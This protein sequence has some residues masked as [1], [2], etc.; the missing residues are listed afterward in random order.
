M[1]K[2]LH[3]NGRDL[4]S[5]ET[6]SGIK[7]GCPCSGSNFAIAADPLVHPHLGSIVFRSSHVGLLA[8]DVAIVARFSEW[9]LSQFIGIWRKWKGASGPALEIP[10][11]NIIRGLP[12]KDRYQARSSSI[13]RSKS[14]ST[15][16]QARLR[17]AGGRCSGE[18]SRG[19][20]MWQHL[21]AR[22][23]NVFI[24]RSLLYKEILTPHNARVSKSYT[25]THATQKL[26][27]STM[28]DDP[29]GGSLQPQGAT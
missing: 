10:K 25:Q 21:T 4:N 9:R 24:P 26:T 15:S 28:D 2:P 6:T 27:Q 14:G 8:N 18:L 13:K 20:M 16:G 3:Y 12:D 29:A 17:S 19:R 22:A 1:C 7:Q 23:I 11:C 5:M